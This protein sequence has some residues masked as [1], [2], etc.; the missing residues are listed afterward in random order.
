MRADNPSDPIAGLDDETKAAVEHL[1]KIGFL[2]N[3]TKKK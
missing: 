2:K 1:D 3:R